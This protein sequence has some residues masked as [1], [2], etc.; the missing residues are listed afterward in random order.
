MAALELADYDKEDG[1]P[2]RDVER[3]GGE[4]DERVESG[5]GRDVYQ[6]KKAADHADKTE[7]INWNS[8]GR[9]DL[10]GYGLVETSLPGGDIVL[11]YEN[12]EEAVISCE[13]PSQT[14]DRG[15]DV[16]ERDEQDQSHHNN[17]QVSG[18][19]RFSCFPVH[20]NDGQAGWSSSDRVDVADA[21]H[22]SDHEC[23]LHD[24]IQGHSRDH[25][26]GNSGSWTID[27]VACKVL[28]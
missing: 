8:E 9:V 28:V 21:E 17:E 7:S 27:F 20:F 5:S 1:D 25:A 23:P 22:E 2:V 14:R 6:C 3:D 26:V 19:D 4:G 13:G 12:T 15:E 18:V 10:G 11:T 24:A 16:E